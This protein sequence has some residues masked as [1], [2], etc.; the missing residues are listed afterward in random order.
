M[1]DS[2]KRIKGVRMT[3]EVINPVFRGDVAVMCGLPDDAD[4]KRFY[5][6][7]TRDMLVF[8][9]ESDEFDVVKEGDKI[10][11]KD[12]YTRSVDSDVRKRTHWCK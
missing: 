6:D 1:N 3:R 12:A 2:E 9:F 4:F 10:P 7:G 5:R 8:V 11:Y